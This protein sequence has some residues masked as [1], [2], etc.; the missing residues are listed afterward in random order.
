MPVPLIRLEPARRCD[1]AASTSIHA[2]VSSWWVGGSGSFAALM[3]SDPVRGVMTVLW[4]AGT[5]VSDPL[6][7]ALADAVAISCI[8][9]GRRSR[10][11]RCSRK[12]SARTAAIVSSQRG[13]TATIAST[14]RATS[15]RNMLIVSATHSRNVISRPTKNQKGFDWKNF[16]SFR[17]RRLRLPTIQYFTI[18]IQKHQKSAS[19]SGKE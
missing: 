13:G 2:P 17:R 15:L 1:C 9:F 8:G 5:V 18:R 19:R 7:L 14:A 12:G 4:L 11:S 16:Q 10:R 6:R 3:R